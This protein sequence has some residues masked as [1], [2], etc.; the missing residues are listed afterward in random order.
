MATNRPDF[1]D[2]D[3][4]A[5]FQ[6]RIAN[7]ERIRH[8]KAWHLVKR[9]YAD[10]H[11]VE[12]IEDWLTTYDPRLS[13]KGKPTTVPLILFP[14]QAEYIQWLQE[15]K[16]TGT[17][18]VVAKSR[19]M[20]ISVITLAYALC[21][22]LF[23]PGVKM[24]FGSRKE[25]LVD[26]MGNPDCLLEKIRMMLRYLPPELL[27]AGFTEQKHARHMKIINPVNGS[28]I[29]GE[30]GDNIGRGG[31]STMY[32]VDEAAF[33][34]RPELIDAAL[35]QNTSS[36]IDV[37]TPNGPDNPFANK[38]FAQGGTPKYITGSKLSGLAF[39]FH[40]TQ[41]PRKN[42]EWYDKEVIRLNDPR[43]VG[44]ELDLDFQTSGED[45]VVRAE[46]V[47][48]SMAL[49]R[50]LQESGDLPEKINGV[51]G[52]DVGGGV[53]ENTF[54]ARW[55]SLVGPCHG[56]IDG[57]TTATAIRFQALALDSMVG[58]IRFDSIGVGKG[59]AATFQRLPIDASGINVGVA[60]SRTMWPDGKKAKDKFRNLKGEL[61]WILRDKLRRTHDHWMFM[62]GTGGVEGNM[63]D[64][65]LLDPSDVD[66]AKQVCIPGFKVLETGK[67]Q[68]ESK[69]DL[70]RRGVPSPDRAEAL[71]LSLAEPRRRARS[72]RVRGVI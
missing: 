7:L 59:V 5:V 69:D 61:W 36:R 35:S 30:A 42:Q 19:D 47:N 22:W 17:D 62:N 41:D 16:D 14:R 40:W 25:D 4:T 37:S 68:I 1:L 45:T 33:L 13:A 53:A 56:W 43:V 71:I 58:T 34:D 44:Q 48:S 72:G 54:I 8:E 52:C 65:L 26:K 49:Y 32:F 46:W 28:S 6:E 31:R 50:H 29:T 63:D 57:D 39:D 38:W 3:Y 64:L 18:G 70:K 23:A 2:P 9:Y 10:G 12:F 55:G 20:G 66:L 60:A 24:S 11:Y 15:R 67:I 21:E 27:P 51:A